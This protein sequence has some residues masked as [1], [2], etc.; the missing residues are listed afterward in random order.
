LLVDDCPHKTA[1]YAICTGFLSLGM[2]L[3]G[4]A[5]GWIEDQAGYVKFFVWVLACTVPSFIVVARLK[6]DPE[7]GRRTK[8]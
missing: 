6:I 1:H 5:V 4:M 8:P 2:M 3:P 7:F